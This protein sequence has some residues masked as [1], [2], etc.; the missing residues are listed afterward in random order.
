[1]QKIPVLT[2]YSMHHSSLTQGGVRLYFEGMQSRSDATLNLSSLLT[3]DPSAPLDVHGEGLLEP[4]HELLDND[5]LRLEGPHDLGLS[6]VNTRG[7][8][9]FILEGYI[10]GVI[11]NECRRCLTDVETEVG[12]S[13]VYSMQYR[14]SVRPLV[15]EEIEK[16]GKEHVMVFG[17]PE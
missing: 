8:D 3:N 13:F 9:A 15:L 7:D 16:E 10:K 1:M 17:S 4:A 14:P 2:R 5:G 6:V 12:A 11:V